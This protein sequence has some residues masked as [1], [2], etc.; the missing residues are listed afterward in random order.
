VR[1]E[2]LSKQFVLMLLVQFS[3]GLGYSAFFLLP[4]YLSRELDAGAAAIGA[5]ASMA[6]AF[7]R[8]R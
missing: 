2:L 4:K 8:F 7:A 3:F 6:P 1:E 5:I